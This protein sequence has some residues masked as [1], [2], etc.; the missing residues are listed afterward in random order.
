[1]YPGLQGTKYAVLGLDASD[2]LGGVVAVLQYFCWP[3][4]CAEGAKVNAAWRE[5]LLNYR[6]NK[7][8]IMDI[9]VACSFD[10]NMLQL[11]QMLSSPRAKSADSQPCCLTPNATHTPPAFAPLSYLDHPAL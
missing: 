11:F 7:A 5:R 10:T 4:S 6:G 2:T 9:C 3:L 8:G 1:M